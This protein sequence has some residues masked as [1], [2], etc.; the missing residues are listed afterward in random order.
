MRNTTKQT[1][2]GV[3]ERILSR[4]SRRFFFFISVKSNTLYS[5]VSSIQ[6][7]FENF[8]VGA[9]SIKN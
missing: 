7:T 2:E 1:L 9:Y 6:M 8:N 4:S 3:Q 5:I